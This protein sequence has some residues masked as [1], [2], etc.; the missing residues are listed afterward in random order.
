MP[1]WSRVLK[2][3]LARPA[4]LFTVAVRPPIL[5]EAQPAAAATED[6]ERQ[7]VDAEALLAEA[8]RQ[9]EMLVREGEARR[10][11]IEKEA[12]EA[13]YR[14]GY[15]TALAAAQAEATRLREEARAVLAEARRLRE[16]II[17]ASEQQVVELA[18]AVAAQVVHSQLQVAPETVVAVVRA[19]LQRLARRRQ[20][21]VFVNPKDVELVRARREELQQELGEGA[22]LYV[23]AD[24]AVAPGG[25][26]VESEGGQVDATIDGQLARL[27]QA[28]LALVPPADARPAGQAEAGVLA[29]EGEDGP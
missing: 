23:L 6:E 1:S 25:C 27:R 4:G 17:A 2:S 26:R 28:L 13:G 8:R 12:Y 7:Q 10:A 22:S 18:L 24:A 19:A 15:A 29:G 9:A 20:L 11:A 3:D 16:E 5:E 14:E 21:V